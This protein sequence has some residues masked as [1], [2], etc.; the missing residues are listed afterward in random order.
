MYPPPPIKHKTASQTAQVLERVLAGGVAEAF[1]AGIPELSEEDESVL[2]LVRA[3][4]LR[5]NRFGC[6]LF[7]YAVSAHRWHL[8]KGIT[9]P[10]PMRVLHLH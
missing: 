5:L 6:S 10:M 3:P 9:G 2:I 7:D 1:F 8:L 4:A